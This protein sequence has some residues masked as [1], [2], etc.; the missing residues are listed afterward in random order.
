MDSAELGRDAASIPAENGGD[1]LSIASGNGKGQLRLLTRESLDGRTYAARLFDQ[2]LSEIENDLGGRAELSTIERTLIRAYV[3]AAIV[4]ENLNAKLLLGEE[5]DFSQHSQC[6]SAMTR[7]ASRLGIRRRARDVV[8]DLA[9][10]LEL[11]A[12]ARAAPERSP[13][14]TEAVE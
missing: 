8:P 2:W 5:I 10:Y 4:A 11:K 1:A 14:S 12:R 3:S 7:V 6:V 9:E 13:I